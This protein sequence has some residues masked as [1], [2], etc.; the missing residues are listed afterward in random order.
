MI[1][2]KNVPGLLLVSGLVAMMMVGLRAEESALTPYQPLS[3]PDEASE[4]PRLP[5]Q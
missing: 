4:Y 3:A 2:L 5:D 1:R